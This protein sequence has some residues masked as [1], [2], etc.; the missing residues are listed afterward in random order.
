MSPRDKSRPKPPRPS[1]VSPPP[2]SPPHAFPHGKAMKLVDAAKFDAM[3]ATSESFAGSEYAKLLH[4][5]IHTPTVRL[6]EATSRGLQYAAW[7]ARAIRLMHQAR[8]LLAPNGKAIAND[9]DEDHWLNEYE[10]LREEIAKYMNESDRVAI[11]KP[12]C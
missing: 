6:A 4:D 8:R 1:K 10:E 9:S 5:K 11:K 2:P 7:V 3:L 12:R